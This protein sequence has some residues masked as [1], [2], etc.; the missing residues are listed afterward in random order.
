MAQGFRGDAWNDFAAKS[1]NRRTVKLARA[2]KRHG[3]VGTRR[4]LA[5]ESR[6]RQARRKRGRLDGV[7]EP[8]LRCAI[9][10]C[11]GRCARGGCRSHVARL[12]GRLV[13]VFL[14]AGAVYCRPRR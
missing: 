12:G 14:I 9:A 1:P 13:P 10:Y 2:D 5:A 11:G 6:P 7:N 3:G 8:R 4:I